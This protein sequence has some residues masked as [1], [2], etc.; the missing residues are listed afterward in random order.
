VKPNGTVT[1]N[2]SKTTESSDG[3]KTTTEK[4]DVE[5]PASP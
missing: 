2:E 5:K 4:K 1:K 3:T